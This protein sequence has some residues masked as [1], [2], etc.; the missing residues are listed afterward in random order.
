MKIEQIR[1]ATG[2]VPVRSLAF[3]GDQLVDWV[4]GGNAWS[5]DGTSWPANRSWGYERLNAAVTDRSGRWAL[6]HERTGTAGLLL[7]DGEIVRAVHRSLYHADA[8]LFPACLF[9][10]P[11]PDPGGERRMLL[12]HCPDS[13][14]RIEIDDAATGERLTRSETRAEPDFFH[15][16]LSVT[17]DGRRL[18]SAGWV[19]HPVDSVVWFDVVE[20]LQD[21]RVL[22]ETQ[23][24]SIN[25]CLAEQSSAA[26]LDHEHLLVG[27]SAEEEDL[28]EAAEASKD[29]RVRLLPCGIA[30]YSTRAKEWTHSTSHS[31]PAGIMMPIGRNQVVTFYKYPRLIDLATGAVIQAWPELPSGNAVSSIVQNRLVQPAL[32]LDAKNSR[33]ALASDGHIHV[34]TFAANQ[35]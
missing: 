32:A 26:W 10:S 33:F 11:T 28:E 3:R 29:G 25:V 20:A 31:Q 22:D 30:T 24:P 8:F 19:W 17:E 7:H 5:L 1:I 4:S 16:R 35:D 23:G 12:A 2:N 21:P 6:V 34:V 13:Y 18:L 15:S 9:E 14:G 27:A